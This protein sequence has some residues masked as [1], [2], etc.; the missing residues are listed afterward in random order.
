MTDRREFF[1]ALAAF[2]CSVLPI[3]EVARAV[4]LS[5]NELPFVIGSETRKWTRATLDTDTGDVLYFWSSHKNPT[6]TR[7]WK[8]LRPGIL[9]FEQTDNGYKFSLNEDNLLNKN[10]A[11]LDVSVSSDLDIRVQL[12]KANWSQTMRDGR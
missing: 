10:V 7:H 3:R 11:Q 12:A 1:G 2:T 6:S 9:R 4:R 8:P 5:W